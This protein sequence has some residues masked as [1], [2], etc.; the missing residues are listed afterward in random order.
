MSVNQRFFPNEEYHA[1][2]HTIRQRMAERDLD[3][4]LVSAPE[5]IYYLIGLDHH[6]YF[7]YHLLIVP[8]EGRLTL[9]TRAMEQITIANQ[10]GDRADFVGFA[11]SDD[12]AAVT[13]R[14][15]RQAGLASA[16]LGVE[17][18][19]AALPPFIIEGIAAGL[20]QAT[21]ADA[22]GLIDAVRQVKS[23]R[24]QAYVRRAAAVSDAMMQA[25]INA[26]G[27]GVSE[28][29]IAAEV[30]RA[31]VLTGGEVPGFSPF[32]RSTPRLGEEHTTWTDRRLEAGDALFIE[33]SGCVRRYHAPMGRLIYIRRAPPATLAIERVCLEAFHST[34]QAIRPGATASQVYRAWQDAVDRAGLAHYRRHHCGYLVGLGFPPSWVGGSMVTGLRH[35]SSLVLQTG[36]TFHLLSWLM[37]TG[38]GDYFVSN[39]A[40]LTESGCDVLTTTPQHLT[41]VS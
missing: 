40:L 31:M 17:K 30:Q 7:A 35:D 38:R 34:V 26:A 16:R 4:C 41:I 25:A 27:V 12:P 6:G 23:P 5:N 21:L 39:P 3:G 1:R 37:G 33:L 13:V 9:I 32:I 20:P 11:D 19:S 8:R 22:S 28:R 14:V 18:K 24:E 36:M 10:V 15:L 29:D 2:L